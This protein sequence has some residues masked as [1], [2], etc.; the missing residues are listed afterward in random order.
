MCA[1]TPRCTSSD[2]RDLTSPIVTNQRL[3]AAVRTRV[4]YWG[5]TGVALLMAAVTLVPAEAWTAPSNDAT[6]HGFD[7][8]LMYASNGFGGSVRIDRDLISIDA[9]PHS[10]PSVN[11]L[12]TPLDGFTASVE[13]SIV[14]S[15]PPGVPLQLGVWSP[16]SGAG[17]FVVFGPAPQDL[18]T[19]QA[20]EHGGIGVHLVGGDVVRTADLGAYT[21]G[22]GSRVSISI[23]KIRGLIKIAVAQPGV[24]REDSITAAD[25]PALFNSLRLALTASSSPDTGSSHVELRNYSLTLPHKRFW[26][27]QVADSRVELVLLVLG[28]A[29]LV[30]V[31][32]AV[33]PRLPQLRRLLAPEGRLPSPRIGRR[34]WVLG[35]VLAYLVGN[36][37]LFPLGG[38]PFDMGDEKLYA[39]VARTYGTAQLFYLPNI[40][41]LAKIWGGVPYGENAFPYEPV[42]AYLSFLLEAEPSGWIRSASSI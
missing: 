8:N 4:L 29:G 36:A 30:L 17:Y 34:A 18:I 13:V 33:A 24:V 25:F 2:D 40:S 31:A 3:P 10:D 38:H 9:P 39:Y 27:S 19:V 22:V 37:L 1:A 32:V 23:D 6:Y 12:T 41:S 20:V 35:A 11:F 42:M 21:A 15:T 7:S 14:D 26:A 5:V 28:F 16:R